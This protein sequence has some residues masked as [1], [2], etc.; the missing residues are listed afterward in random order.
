MK[1]SKKMTL[2]VLLVFLV[3]CSG[4]APVTHYFVIDPVNAEAIADIDGR[5]VQI[6]DLKL[7]QYLERF[8]IARR[9]SGNQLTFSSHHQ[10]SENLRKNLYRTMTRNLSDLL[11]TA[12]VG[13]AISRSLSAPDYLVRVSIEAFEQGADGRVVIA[14][15]YQITNAEGEVLATERFDGSSSRDTGDDYAEMVVEL[16]QLFG[17]LSRDIAGV[18]KQLD[19][20]N[21]D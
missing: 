9:K 8:Q 17:D 3:G 20:Q 4:S 18:I 6:L 5:S 11:G 13:S 21:D 10:W 7:P 14:A 2:L 12:D 1:M 16:Q 19:E 15:R